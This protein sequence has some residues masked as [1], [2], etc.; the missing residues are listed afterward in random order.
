M[1]RKPD[2][3]NPFFTAK[4]ASSF[5]PHCGTM[6][7]KK[8][9]RGLKAILNH[10]F[11]LISTDLKKADRLNAF[12]GIFSRDAATTQRQKKQERFVWLPERIQNHEKNDLR[13]R[14]Y[15]S[16]LF[17]GLN[18]DSDR[19]LSCFGIGDLKLGDS[20]RL[21]PAFKSSCQSCKSLLK[22]A[23]LS[24]APRLRVKQVFNAF[25]PVASC[26]KLFSSHSPAFRRSD[27]SAWTKA[28][29]PQPSTL[30]NL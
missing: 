14:V 25:K 22:T 17:H 24:A 29:S 26:Y 12:L 16:R 18:S 5:V 20:W 19:N 15:E 27:R 11:S 10:L 9:R 23:F 4:D 8:F 1:R 13:K 3:Q 6:A 30:Q 21:A 2:R 28:D 7:D